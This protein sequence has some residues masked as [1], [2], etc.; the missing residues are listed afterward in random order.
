[1]LR[2]AAMFTTART[3]GDDPP[4]SAISVMKQRSILILSNGKR[5]S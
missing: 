4:D 3:M 5:C 1:M 2:A